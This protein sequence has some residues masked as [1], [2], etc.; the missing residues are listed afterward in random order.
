MA[1]PY[2]HGIVGTDGSPTAQR[3]VDAAGRLATALDLPVVAAVAYERTRPSDL[4]PPS[5]RAESPGE[6]WQGASYR[7]AADVAEDAVDAL[8]RC[9]VSDA[10]A[11][12]VEGHAAEALIDLAAGYVDPLLVVGSRGLN[13][14][15]R[16]LL[17]SVPHR[18][19]HHADCDVLI[20]RTEAPR[21]GDV[22]RSV[23][24]GTDG[25]DTAQLAV[26]RAVALSSRLGASVRLLSAGPD[27]QAKAAVERAGRAAEASGVAWTA[28]VVEGPAGEALIAAG[29]EVDLL[30]V[31]SRGMTGAQRFLLGSVPNRVSHHADCDVLIV[32]TT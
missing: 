9:G 15:T 31:G 18:V 28:D 30:V 11:A 19:S 32:R 16:F 6:D 7:A 13:A 25:S 4:G 27:A 2:R 1:G 22:A 3:A 10:Q 23:L 17:G 21:A 26:E 12:V 29:A 8:R 14:S 5:M 20:V 24:V